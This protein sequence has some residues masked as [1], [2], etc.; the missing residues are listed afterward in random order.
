MLQKIA[1]VAIRAPRRIIVTG[2][3]VFI[4]AAV[5]GVPVAKSLSPGGFQDPHSESARAIS[6]LSEKF[7]Q[8]GQQVLILVTAPAGSNSEQARK[9]GTDLV[10]QLQKSPLVY[11]VSSPWTAPAGQSDDL[12]SRDGK[13]GLVVVNLKGG[14]NYAQ[15]NAQTLADQF[16]HD[17]D[18]VTVR[19]GGAAMQYAQIN[20]QNQAD[21]LIMEM[22]ALPLSFL[23][24]IWVFGGLLAAAL[25]MALGALAVVGSMSVLRLITFTTEVSIFALNLSTALGLALAIDYTL[26]IVS[27]YRDELAEG[28]DRDEALVRTMATSGRTV[29]FSAVT[30]ALSMSATVAFPMYF[31]KSFAYAGVATV[32]FVAAASI[33]ITPAAIV[34][35]GPRL[36]ALDVR[37]LVR[38]KLLRNTTEPVHKPVQQLFWYRSTKFVMRRWAPIGLTVV[39]LLLLLGYPFLRVTWGFPDDRVLPRSA[40]AHQVGDQL[41]NDFAHD[42]ATSVPV[43]IPDATGLSPADL[44]NYAADLSRVAD[45]SAVSAPGGTFAAG[46]RVGPPAGPTGLNAGSAF[47]TVSSTAP[48]FST[49]NDT[50]LRRLHQVPGPPGRSVEMGGVAQVN[51]DSVDAVTDRLPLVLGLMAAITFVLLFLLTGSVLLPAK[52]LACNVLSLTAAF[53]ALVWIFQDGHL[54]ALGTTPSGTLVA[55]MPVLLFCIAFGLSMDYEVFL[56]SRIREYWLASGAAR[57]AK[58]TAKQAH[59]ANDESVALGVARTGRVITAAALVMSMSFAA[60]IAAHVSFMRMFGLGLT[61]AVFADATLVRMVVVPAFMHVMG[62]WNW[63]APKPL[64]W[65]HDRI[66]ISEGAADESVEFL[67]PPRAPD[68]V[69]EPVVGEPVPN[70]R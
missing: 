62:R 6:V 43:V 59:A 34:L 4:A 41:R 27:R 25:P 26:L 38:R 28:Y 21:L 50:Q 15:S 49:A 69:P 36:D 55:N 64:A 51:R 44:N 19:A 32:A 35:L 67:E 9:V 5:F 8:S 1:R 31:L 52:A 68:E 39:A 33:F 11:N 40:S 48:L 3:L 23:V 2:I 12:V 58:P 30:V 10:D 56:L 14:E 66:G 65:L 7:G 13:S 42:S 47:L 18:G 54:G 61:L 29:L 24:L 57:P 37:R 22:I 60:L 63:W 16:I 20:T 53:G 46:N 17:R 70:I 45:V